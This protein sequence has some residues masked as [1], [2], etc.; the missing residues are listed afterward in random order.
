MAR[1]QEACLPPL[2]IISFL[3]TPDGE[4]SSMSNLLLSSENFLISGF[5]TDT[6][7]PSES[8]RSR[9][10][11]F[12][13]HWHH[14]LQ[15]SAPI[16][17]LWGGQ[18]VHMGGGGGSMFIWGSLSPLWTFATGRLLSADVHTPPK[19]YLH[20]YTNMRRSVAVDF[21]GGKLTKKGMVF[22]V[23]RIILYLE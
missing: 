5:G 21:Y 19:E 2:F 23:F 4:A 20:I 1:S 12:K 22:G 7:A 13:F 14:I 9:F 10:I 16:R 3:N 8:G 15:R 17:T 11:Y 6:S 18:R